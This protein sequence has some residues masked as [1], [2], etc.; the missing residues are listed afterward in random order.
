MDSPADLRLG[1]A[2]PDARNV[3]WNARTVKVIEVEVTEGLG[4][5]NAPYR[6]VF[7]YYRLDGT[8]LARV[9]QWEAETKPHV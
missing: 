1:Q 5:E 4:S 9:D 7:Y 3:V 8:R 2:V 6:K